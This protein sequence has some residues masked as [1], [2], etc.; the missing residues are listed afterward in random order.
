MASWSQG[1][2]STPDPPP[3]LFL[4][5]SLPSGSYTIGNGNICI[6][7]F[8]VFTHFS[9]FSRHAWEKIPKMLVFTRVYVCVKAKLTFVSFFF[10]FF[11]LNLSLIKLFRKRRIDHLTW[12]IVESSTGIREPG[13]CDGSPAG[14]RIAL[15]DNWKS[16]TLLPQCCWVGTDRRLIQGIGSQVSIMILIYL[17]IWIFS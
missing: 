3:W 9:K 16:Q 4:N 1:A 6:F 8:C 17:L 10:N 13:S 12:A 11:I 2:D 14:R 7:V 5:L 15:A